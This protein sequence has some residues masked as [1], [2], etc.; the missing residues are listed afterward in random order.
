MLR[1]SLINICTHVSYATFDTDLNL[2]NKK[3]TLASSQCFWILHLVTLGL[4]FNECEKEIILFIISTNTEF[5]N[6]FVFFIKFRKIITRTIFGSILIYMFALANTPATCTLCLI[7]FQIWCYSCVTNVANWLS[8]ILII[9][10][11]DIHLNPGPQYHNNFFTF[12]SWNVNSLA[13]DDFQRVRLI[14]AHN[15]IFNYDMISI[16][17]TSLNDSVELPETLLNDYTF[18]PANSSANTRHGGVGLF[19]K[20]SLPVIIRNDLSFD[21]SIVV[22]LKFGLKKIFFLS[23]LLI[24]FF[25][26]FPRRIFQFPA[27]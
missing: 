26:I 27:I 14:E 22:E 16:C 19:Y 11:N 18:V 3:K 12:M 7:V 9:L 21:E 10:S 5:G 15:S 20:N 13:K 1:L 8:I 25:K 2:Y 24:L 17:E 23:N 4:L 6:A